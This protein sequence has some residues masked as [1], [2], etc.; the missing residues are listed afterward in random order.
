MAENLRSKTL[1]KIFLVSLKY[2]PIMIA[3]TYML[4]TALCWMGIDCAVLSN[5]AGV[6]L[7]TWVFMYVASDVFS[8]CIYHKL[9]LWYILVTDIINITDYYIKIPMSTYTLLEMH[10]I[11]IGI[12]LFIIL[13]LYVANNKKLTIKNSKQHRFRK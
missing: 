7:F 13:Y 8:F 6:S 10:S 12:T 5:I 1:Y 4:N 11:I 9:F 3:L 2:I